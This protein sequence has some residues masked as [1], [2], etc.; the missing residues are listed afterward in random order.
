MRV[1]HRPLPARRR[2]TRALRPPDARDSGS[3]SSPDLRSVD[4]DSGGREPA[5]SALP[6]S[7]VAHVDADRATLKLRGELDLLSV[8]AFIKSFGEVAP[9]VSEVVLDL[10]ELDFID[11]SGLRA[12]AVAAQQAGTCDRAVRIRSPRPQPQRLFDLFN[13]NQI[14]PIE[15]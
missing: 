3:G 1:E 9:A 7:T 4:L 13:F 11:G 8:S 15:P 5:T 6:F 14:V 2:V 10:A 12:I